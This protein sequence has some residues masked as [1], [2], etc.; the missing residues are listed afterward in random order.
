MAN[1]PYYSDVLGMP[2]DGFDQG[3]EINSKI[4]K[5]QALKSNDR[6]FT[7][8]SC[9]SWGDHKLASNL[10]L[11]LHKNKPWRNLFA[12]S[13]YSSKQLKKKNVES[14]FHQSMY[15]SGMKQKML[16]F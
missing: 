14:S 4:P 5:K 2:N 8:H 6:Q 9:S 15:Y 12:N 11:T 3:T 1:N 16:H 10:F 7:D 13:I